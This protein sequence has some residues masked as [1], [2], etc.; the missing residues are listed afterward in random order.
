M[1]L[2]YQKKPTAKDKTYLPLDV[3]FISVIII[4]LEDL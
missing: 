3:K 2:Y 1:N 4:F